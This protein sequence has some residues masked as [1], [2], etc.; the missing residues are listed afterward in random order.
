MDFDF[1]KFSEKYGKNAI[2]FKFTDKKAEPLQTKIGGKPDLPP[3]FEWYYYEGTDYRDVKANRPLSFMAQI[4]CAEIKK[5]DKDNLLPEKGMLYF[6]YELM[7]MEWGFSPESKDC[8]KVFYY[9]GDLSELKQTDFP[10]DLDEE[11]IIPEIA[12]DFQTFR[13]IPDYCE[14]RLEIDDDEFDEFIEEYDDKR[15][16]NF[17]DDTRIK[18]L[19]YADTIQNCMQYECEYNSRGY[20]VGSGIPEISE[21]EKADIRNHLQDWIL[22]FQMGTIEIGNFELMFGDCG[23]IY[24]WIRKDD[25][26]NRNFDNIQLVLQCY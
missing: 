13:D 4:N 17:P 3:D 24:F 5:Y 9:D 21:D 14:T 16:E 1:E 10:D 20:S 26:K 11:C 23:R 6:F 15:Y 2:A 25:L 7:T 19:G 18:L 8:A 22:L 12:V